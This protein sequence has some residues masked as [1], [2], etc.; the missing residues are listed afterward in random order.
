MILENHKLGCGKTISPTENGP[1]KTSL[2]RLLDSSRMQAGVRH[3]EVHAALASV[4][5]DRPRNWVEKISAPRHFAAQPAQNRA[6][7]DWLAAQFK[8]GGYEVRRQGKYDNL[9][10]LPKKI[11]RE[12][13]LI[14]AHYDSKPETP[15][16]DDNG[17]AV[18][19]MLGC[20]EV[21]A[22]TAPNAPVCFAGFNCEEDG[23]PCYAADCGLKNL[24]LEI[25]ERQAKVLT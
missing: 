21:M 5:E 16:A 18:A 13:T 9:L 14:G 19:A 23:M 11:S 8:G 10:A 15:G 6:T 2:M 25:L 4:S 22:K 1:R 3:A 20:T 17:S 12:M 24:L 7:T